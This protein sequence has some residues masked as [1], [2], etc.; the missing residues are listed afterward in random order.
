MMARF[1]LHSFRSN[2]FNSNDNMII[3]LLLYEM[4]HYTQ[5][6]IYGQWPSEHHI[7][8]SLCFSFFHSRNGMAHTHAEKYYNNGEWQTTKPQFRQFEH[9]LQVRIGSNNIMYY[10]Y[11]YVC[12]YFARGHILRVH[13][14]CIHTQKNVIDGNL[15][16]SA[17]AFRLW[18]NCEVVDHHFVSIYY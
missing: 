3:S 5:S 16:L 9:D 4:E 10:S 6:C 7:D 8:R 18:L 12:C 2:L 15:L 11:C 13:I 1:S 17:F 14:L